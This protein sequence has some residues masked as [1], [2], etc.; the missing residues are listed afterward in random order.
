MDDNDADFVKD[1]FMLDSDNESVVVGDLGT[2]M[3]ATE[4]ERVTNTD[5]AAIVNLILKRGE[6]D[7][8]ERAPHLSWMLYT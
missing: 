8:N 3:E 6:N 2:D 5:K 7:D 4:L 1:I